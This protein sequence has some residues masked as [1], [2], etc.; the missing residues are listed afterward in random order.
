MLYIM[1]EDLQDGVE[2]RIL[3]LLEN[4]LIS[5][6]ELAKKLSMRRDIVAG[7]LEALK[8]QGKIEMIK[9]GRSNVYTPKKR[10]AAMS[11]AH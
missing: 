5:T 3:L 2:Q 9:I 6:S 11:I 8:D 4:N 7:Y 1:T 10:G